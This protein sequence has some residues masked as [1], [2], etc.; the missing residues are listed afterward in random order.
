[1][2]VLS[3]IEEFLQTKISTAQLEIDRLGV[4][5]KELDSELSQVNDRIREDSVEIEKLRLE[6][7]ISVKDGSSE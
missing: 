7:G 1:M 5:A 3:G 2:D 4:R 6:S